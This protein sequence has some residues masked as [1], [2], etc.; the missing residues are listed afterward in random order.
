MRCAKPTRERLLGMR[1]MTRSSVPLSARVLAR[2]GRNGILVV[3]GLEKLTALEP[4][5]LLVDTGDPEV[6]R[7]L[8]GWMRVAVGPG[9]STLIRIEA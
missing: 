6:D 9:R 7:M 8:A 2:V 4:L 5:R 1:P 3:A